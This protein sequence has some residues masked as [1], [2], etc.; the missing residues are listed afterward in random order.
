MSY[1]IIETSDDASLDVTE[2]T[3]YTSHNFQTKID[4]I[5]FACGLIQNNLIVNNGEG[6]IDCFLPNELIN[7]NIFNNLLNEHQYIPAFNFYRNNTFL[8]F[9]YEIV[10]GGIAYT[11][12][13]PEQLGNDFILKKRVFEWEF[14]L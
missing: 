3:V 10:F 12:I 1:L 11:A 7:A 5:K 9:K 8:N 14:I 13:E 4:T 6:V 2:Y